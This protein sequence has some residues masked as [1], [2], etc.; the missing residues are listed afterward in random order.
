MLFTDFVLCIVKVEHSLRERAVL[1][2]GCSGAH[3]SVQRESGLDVRAQI[4]G[5]TG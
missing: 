2:P 4:D 5:Q 3:C 1:K